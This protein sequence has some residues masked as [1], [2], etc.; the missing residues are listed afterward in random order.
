MT[1]LLAWKPLRIAAAILAFVLLSLV[2]L[3]VP[4]SKL[5]SANEFLPHATCY[6]RNERLIW[7]HASSDLVIGLSYVAI[8]STLAYLVFRA[9]RE[10]PFHWMFLAFGLFIITCGFTHFMEVWTVWQPVY[11]LS[12]YVKIVTGIASASTAIFLPTLVPKVIRLIREARLSTERKIQLEQLNEE[13][14]GANEELKAFTY[15]ASHDLRAPLRTMNSM[16]TLLLETLPENTDP[17]ARQFATRIQN[18]AY[19]MNQLLD[20]LLAYSAFYK[21]DTPIS[22]FSPA[23]IIEEIISEF[24]T[25]IK[26][27]KAQVS[28]QGV[29]PDVTANPT[30][31]KMVLSNLIANAVK[32]VPEDRV[33]RVEISAHNAEGQ[34]E[35][36]VKDNGP[37]IPPQFRQ[38]IFE[39]FERLHR[40]QS[41]TGL[42]L[43]IVMRGIQKMRGQAGVEPNPEGTGSRFWV[44]L[45]AA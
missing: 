32:Y 39:P 17:E 34:V 41:G 28:I 12:G 6:L 9:R 24:E 11:W 25:D 43:A 16:S 27:R 37:G 29:M 2:L 30:L 45:P 19:R 38:K 4:I 20:D 22:K 13:L 1:E 33:P 40:D 5:I 15:S 14:S 35:I 7:L 18:G 23:P 26:H 36:S 8:S 3:P 10:I 42:G 31:L 44:R 21:L